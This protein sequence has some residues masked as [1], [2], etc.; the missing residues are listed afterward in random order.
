MILKRELTLAE[1]GISKSSTLHVIIENNLVEN[2]Q[3]NQ[4]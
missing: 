2:D 4:L 1:A 3:G